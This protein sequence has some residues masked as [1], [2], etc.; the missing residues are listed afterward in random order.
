MGPSFWITWVCSVFA[1]FS[2]GTEGG[3]KSEKEVRG[4]KQRAERW[5]PQSRNLGPCWCSSVGWVSS[6]KPKGCQVD[7]Y[8]SNPSNNKPFKTPCAASTRVCV[9]SEVEP[10]VPKWNRIERLG[11]TVRALTWHLL[12]VSDEGRPCKVRGHVGLQEEWQS[13]T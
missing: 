8:P 2:G 5:G 12:K 4:R 9:M 7:S 1:R 10:Y 6:C 11:L 3:R 13:G